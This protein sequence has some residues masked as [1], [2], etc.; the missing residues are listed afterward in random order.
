[1][2]VE[3]RAQARLHF[4]FFDPAG[5]RGRRFGG[6]GLAI[7]RPRTVL[8]LEPATRLEVEGRDADRVEILAARFLDRLELPARARIRV[9]EAIPAHVGLGSGTQLALALAAGLSR[10]H[11]VDRPLA[12]LCVLMDRSRRSGVGFHLFER[13]GLVVEGG[14]PP[15][16]RPVPSPPPLLARQEFPESWRVIV[17]IP[18]A[19]ETVSG[20]AEEEAFRRLRPA[21]DPAVEGIPHLLLMRLL[22]ALAERD[23]P[24][25]GGALSEIQERVGACFAGVQDGPFHPAGAALVR[26]LKEAGACGVGQSSWGPAV[27][28]FAGD[29]TEE[30]R[31]V[32]VI[33]AADPL[34]EILVTRGCNTGAGIGRP[35]AARAPGPAA[36]RRR[37]PGGRS[38]APA[39]D[40]D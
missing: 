12:D 24:G 15:G 1:M 6:M 14:H 26:R 39:A 34:A 17:A 33:A 32:S 28:A 18:P 10:L 22:P 38:R 3:V 13:G 35:P 4:G 30:R 23:L 8:Q 29:E 40:H 19:T 36:A 37:A 7:A 20:E 2:R 16:E 25:F 31:V 21:P 5:G 9:T 11:R 27:Y